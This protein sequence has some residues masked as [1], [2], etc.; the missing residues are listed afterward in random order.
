MGDEA[1]QGLNERFRKTSAWPVFVALG[2]V[3]SEVGVVLGIFPVTVGGLLLFGGAVA[4]ILHEAGYLERPTGALAVLGA[5]LVGIGAV[6]TVAQLGIDAITLGTLVD[7]AN[8]VVYRAT[9]IA[10]AGV[11]LLA[12][13]TAVELGTPQ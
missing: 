11:T 6:V 4:G 2:V 5:V 13:A 8:P 12:M 10:V 9:A 7:R 1:V 3:V